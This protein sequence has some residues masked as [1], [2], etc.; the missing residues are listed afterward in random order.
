MI[1][2]LIIL[3]VLLLVVIGVEL[4]LANVMA[5]LILTP[6]KNACPTYQSVRD[7]KHGDIEAE[8]EAFSNTDWEEYDAWET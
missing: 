4:F 1:T 8:R 6:A 2:V 5:S 7:R 3:G